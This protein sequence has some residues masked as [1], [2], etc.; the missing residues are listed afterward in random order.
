MRKT[1]VSLR[2]NFI[3]ANV[4][5]RT[6][7]F[8]DICKSLTFGCVLQ[9]CGTSGR[10]LKTYSCSNIQKLS[11]RSSEEKVRHKSLL[12]VKKSP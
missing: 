4:I 12:T 9:H 8:G 11:M 5:S 2:T 10:L 3:S 1:L 6:S 7:L